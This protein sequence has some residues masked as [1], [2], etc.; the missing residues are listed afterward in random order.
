MPTVAEVMGCLTEVGIR[1][2]RGYPNTPMPHIVTM[3][4]AVNVHKAEDAAVTYAALVC[5]PKHMGAAGCEDGAAKVAAV[6]HNSGAACTWGGCEF[7]DVMGAFTVTVYGRWEEPPP[8]EEEEPPAV[9]P[10]V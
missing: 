6:W 3:A 10:E 7:D 1:A 2:S 8:V 5:V 4:T 9:A